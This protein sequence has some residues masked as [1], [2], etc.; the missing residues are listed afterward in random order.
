MIEKNNNF[1]NLENDAKI[2]IPKTKILINP[3]EVMAITGLEYDCSCKLI[4]ECNDELKAKGFRTFRGKVLR[5][6]LLER[7]GDSSASI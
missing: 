4:R 3:Q 6:Y 7:L 1:D 5:S 2:S